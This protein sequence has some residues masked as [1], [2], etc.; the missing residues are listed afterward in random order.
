LTLPAA[1][2]VACR[3]PRGFEPVRNLRI[4]WGTGA[5]DPTTFAFD[6][7]VTTEVRVTMTARGFL[8]ISALT[9]R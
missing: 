9:A 8:R 3:T 6:P 5:N 4:T 1:V 7:V 2:E